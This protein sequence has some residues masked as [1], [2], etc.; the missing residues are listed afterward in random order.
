MTLPFILSVTLV[1]QQNQTASPRDAIRAEPVILE[2]KIGTV[3]STVL[4]ARRV[5]DVALL[6]VTPVLALAEL[7]RVSEQDEYLSVDSLAVMLHVPISV[8]W[9]EL[10]VTIA[11]DG[12]FPIIRRAVREH[13]RALLNAARDDPRVLHA[14][15]RAAPLLPRNLIV[16]YDATTSTPSSVAQ[17]GIRLGLGA[18]FIGGALDVDVLRAAKQRPG[19]AAWHWDREFPRAA[20][21]R[22]ARVGRIP[23]SSNSAIG[24]GLFLSSDPPSRDDT[25]PV[26]LVGMLGPDSDMEV[27]RDDLLVYSGET[28]SFGSYRIPVP[29]SLGSH[30]ITVMSYG[31]GGEQRSATRYVSVSA[32]TLAAHATA[33]DVAIGRCASTACDHA[34]ETMVRYAPAERLT[35]GAGLRIA[36][37]VQQRARVQPSVLLATRLRDDLNASLGYAREATSAGLQYAPAQAFDASLMYA[38]TRANSTSPTPPVRHATMG[39]SAILRIPHTGYSASAALTL[40]GYEL[41]DTRRLDFAI[42]LPVGFLYLRPFIDAAHQFNATSPSLERGVYAEGPIPFWLPIGSR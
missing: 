37:G 27:Y 29:A 36:T 7:H 42:S 10:T 5:G 4:V 18:N 40:A 6:P 32:N 9:D 41:G 38:S 30:R 12:R 23:Y 15:D 8:D 16:D 13:Q 11:G 22:Y 35:A 28:D 3:A 17:A 31:P 26:T 1:T 33:Y 39:A 24:A 25:P 2:V 14:I 21:L 34:V 20:F 19:I